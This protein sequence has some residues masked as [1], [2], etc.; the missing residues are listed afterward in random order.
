[1]SRHELCEWEES[2]KR[3]NFQIILTIKLLPTSKM[4]SICVRFMVKRK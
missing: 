4:Y 2:V 1:M 3:I